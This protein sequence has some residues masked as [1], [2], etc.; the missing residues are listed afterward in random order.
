MTNGYHP[1]LST[2]IIVIASLAATYVCFSVI[3]YQ[4]YLIVST[5]QYL[6]PPST[7]YFENHSI[8]TR[9]HRVMRSSPLITQLPSN[10]GKFQTFSLTC[11]N[12]E[13]L[14]WKNT[15]T[16]VDSAYRFSSSVLFISLSLFDLNCT[17]MH[18]HLLPST[19]HRFSL[20]IPRAP[21]FSPE[22][23]QVRALARSFGAVWYIPSNIFRITT[24]AL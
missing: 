10:K 1:K 22:A 24:A 5:D 18:H 6:L 11:G 12:E 21:S 14:S 3:S 17:N 9:V 13:A 16:V 7:T 8:A 19:V 23:L 4:L 15:T 20:Q 2:R